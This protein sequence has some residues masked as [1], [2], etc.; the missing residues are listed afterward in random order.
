MRA[1]PL[2]ALCMVNGAVTPARELDHIL[3]CGDNAALFWDSG[4]LQAL[5]RECHETKTARENAGAPV[6]GQAKWRKQMQNTDALY[7]IS[8]V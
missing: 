2:C 8:K 4:N 7:P 6:K 5:C 1:G 3:P